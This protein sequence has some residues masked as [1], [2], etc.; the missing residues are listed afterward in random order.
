MKSAKRV[1]SGFY[2]FIIFQFYYP[3]PQVAVALQHH[4][5]Q[6]IDSGRALESLPVLAAADGLVSNAIGRK[7]GRKRIV[8]QTK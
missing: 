8:I 1:D 7:S 4:G 2:C 3:P 6:L 5:G